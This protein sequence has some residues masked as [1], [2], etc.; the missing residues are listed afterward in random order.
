MPNIWGGG[1]GGISLAT[2]GSGTANKL[3]KFNTASSVTDSNLTDD[4]TDITAAKPIVLAAATTS[5]PSVTVSEGT[6]PTSPD[7][8]DIWNESGVLK[9]HDG[10]TTQTIAK[11]AD[12]ETLP[13]AGGVAKLLTWDDSDLAVVASGTSGQVLTSN[14]AAAP[15]FQTAASAG[16]QLLNYQQDASA[17]TGDSTDQTIYTYTM[18]GNTMA[19]GKCVRITVRTAHTTGS[20]NVTHKLHFGATEVDSTGFTQANNWVL[21]AYVCNDAGSTS[22]QQGTVIYKVRSGTPLDQTALST[23]A[24]DTTGNVVIKATFNVANTDQVTPQFWMVELLP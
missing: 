3:V 11:T 1:G 12:V 16:V 24:A 6:A 5:G 21:M 9:Y 14:G 2:S 22:A 8:G 15:T 23:P 19:A 4:G 7:S 18:P 13:S 20:A 17:L 10:T